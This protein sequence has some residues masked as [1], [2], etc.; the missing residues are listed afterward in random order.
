MS[1]DAPL[2]SSTSSTIYSSPK[3]FESLK[4]S[5]NPSSKKDPNT[6]HV[7]PYSY[8]QRLPLKE[9]QANLHLVANTFDNAKPKE[10]KPSCAIIPTSASPS[11]SIPKSFIQF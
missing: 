10:P 1:S 11:S 3:D 8:P 2:P 7:V 9:T 4:S 6:F 5:T